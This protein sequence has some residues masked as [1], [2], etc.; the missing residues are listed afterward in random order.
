MNF[1]LSSWIAT[2]EVGSPV[3]YHYSL[4]RFPGVVDSI[5]PYGIWVMVETW[6]GDML[7]K[8]NPDGQGTYSSYITPRDSQ[9]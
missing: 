3:T 5:E 4:G 9:P 1:P 7:A 2:L 6:N 8:V